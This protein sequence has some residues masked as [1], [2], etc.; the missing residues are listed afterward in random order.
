MLN[1]ISQIGFPRV[2]VLSRTIKGISVREESKKFQ[3]R[4]QLKRGFDT[5]DFT[6]W[7]W[8][9]NPKFLERDQETFSSDFGGFCFGRNEL[10]S[11][12]IKQL[13]RHNSLFV[14]P[15]KRLSY[16]LQVGFPNQNFALWQVC[17]LGKERRFRRNS[18]FLE[19]WN[20]LLRNS[21]WIR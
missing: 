17:L 20:C 18:A 7:K 12:L 13:L 5:V 6:S 21:P 19:Y 1:W 15:A 3:G 10:K 4:M 9:G 14:T 11:G 16:Q 8:I 2:G